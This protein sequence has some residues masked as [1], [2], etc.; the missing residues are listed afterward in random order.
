MNNKNVKAE[1][2]RHA[3]Q[4]PPN[5]AGDAWQ[6]MDPQTAITATTRRLLVQYRTVLR[7]E[8]E[9]E[10]ARVM[11]EFET[12]AESIDDTIAQRIG[13]RLPMLIQQEA[14]SIF[15]DALSNATS[16][17]IDPASPQGIGRGSLSTGKQESALS[18][19]QIP[20]PGPDD[21]HLDPGMDEAELYGFLEPE[22]TFD[23]TEPAPMESGPVQPPDPTAHPD[24]VGAAEASLESDDDADAEDV[25]GIPAKASL[26]SDG[27][28]DSGV[29]EGTVRLRVQANQSIQQLSQF[30]RELRQTPRLRLLRMNGNQKGGMDIWLGLREP[31]RLKKILEEMAGVSQV[32]VPLDSR[33]NDRERSLLV[34]LEEDS[35]GI[36]ENAPPQN[37]PL[38]Q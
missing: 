29:Y 3:T 28:A 15:Q 10:V 7:Q 32:G 35:T 6:V 31:L 24:D 38:R 37:Q 33:P 14:H 20:A 25:A 21:T 2:R 11:Q 23:S 22:V 13:A 1:V 19:E 34:L 27:D 8:L 5:T 26:E 30:V 18:A 9:R 36:G 17:L 4:E 12:V 16:S